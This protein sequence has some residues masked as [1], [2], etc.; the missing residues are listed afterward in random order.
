MTF[1]NYPFRLHVAGSL[2]LLT[3]TFCLWSALPVLSG[4]VMQPWATEAPD[5][6]RSVTPTTLIL[7]IHF[8]I[9]LKFQADTYES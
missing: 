8:R 6:W 4:D 7:Q 3:Y 5:T 9:F 2:R 1:R